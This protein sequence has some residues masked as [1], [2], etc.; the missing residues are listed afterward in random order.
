MS[1]RFPGGTS[2]GYDYLL[3]LKT[4]FMHS[5][6]TALNVFNTNETCCRLEQLEKSALLGNELIG[7]GQNR[8]CA[9]KFC[10]RVGEGLSK[11]AGDTQI[12]LI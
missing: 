6:N 9:V 3:V 11:I 2:T 5:D 1:S 7:P 4:Q 10:K 12:I 8:R